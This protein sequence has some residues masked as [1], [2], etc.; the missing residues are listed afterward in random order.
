MGMFDN[1]DGEFKCPICGF[2]LTDFQTKSEDCIMDTLDFR[3]CDFFYTA[4]PECDSWVE[5]SLHEEI[6]SRIYNEIRN[7]RETLIADHYE[8]SAGKC[9]ERYGEKLEESEEKVS[10]LLK[11]EEEA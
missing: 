8:V 3:L 6:R 9:E 7:L 1:V 4:C 11:D 10:N 5:V 2:L